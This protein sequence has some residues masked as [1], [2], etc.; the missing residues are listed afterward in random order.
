LFAE[1]TVPLDLAR[2]LV[3]LEAGDE[4]TEQECTAGCASATGPDAAEQLLQ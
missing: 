1:V 2:V 3:E 4:Q